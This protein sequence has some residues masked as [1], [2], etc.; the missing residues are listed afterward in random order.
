MEVM[1]ERVSQFVVE[2]LIQQANIGWN[3][4]TVRT[5]LKSR[6]GAE[7]RHRLLS[8]ASVHPW[9]LTNRGLLQN[10]VRGRSTS[11]GSCGCSG[12]NASRIW[13]EVQHAVFFRAEATNT[14]LVEHQGC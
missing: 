8:G 6:I 1:L 5:V 10:Q 2:V 13:I 3:T 9:Q 11:H 12:R 7:K 14:S 4:N